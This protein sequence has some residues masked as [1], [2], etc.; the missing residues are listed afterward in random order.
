MINQKFIPLIDAANLIVETGPR[1][2]NAAGE[3]EAVTFL[4]SGEPGIGKTS[5]MKGIAAKLGLRAVYMDV[6]TMDISD[7]GTPVPDRE[8]RT[9]SLYPNE[10]WGLHLN[11]PLLIFLDEFSKGAKMVQTVL[12]PLL[13]EVDGHRRIGAIKL[14]PDTVV[15]ATG[16]LSTDGVG[17]KLLDHTR[18]RFTELFVRKCTNDEWVEWA[19]D[20]GLAP[21]LISWAYKNPRLF[22]SYVDGQLESTDYVYNPTDASQRGKS[23]VTPRSLA[24]CSSIVTAYS[25]KRITYTQCMAALQGSIGVAATHEFMAYLDLGSQL[26]TPHEIKVNPTAATV[27][28]AAPAQII[29]VLNALTWIPGDDSKI[30]A[31]VRADLDSWFVYFERLAKEAQI[32]FIEAAMTSGKRAEGKACAAYKLMQTMLT[33]RAYLKWAV[34]NQYVF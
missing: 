11:E 1:R 6:P 23:F 3:V 34:D 29:C 22:A 30:A 25:E 4:L 21:E 18:D 8:T 26:P 15:V 7:I 9:T 17:D 20:R 31:D 19:V 32:M 10:H 33:H 5:I 28:Q 13:L 14:H 24:K 12:H 16:N 2:I 27:P